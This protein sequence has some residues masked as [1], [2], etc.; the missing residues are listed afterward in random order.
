MYILCIYCTFVHVCIFVSANGAVGETP[1]RRNAVSAK[2]RVGEAPWRRNALSGEPCRRNA[3]SAKGRVGET[4]CRR[5]AVSANRRVGETPCRRKGC[6]ETPCRRNVQ[7]PFRRCQPKFG[8]AQERQMC[9]AAIAITNFSFQLELKSHVY[10]RGWLLRP[11]NFC[12][13][14]CIAQKVG[15]GD[16]F[17]L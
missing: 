1:C 4:P 10:M 11:K 16:L 12:A 15:T 5:T 14:G 3:L 6:G 2:R 9:L 7:L 17:V 8:G 13:S